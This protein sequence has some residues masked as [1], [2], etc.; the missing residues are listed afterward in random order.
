[1]NDAGLARCPNKDVLQGRIGRQR[2]AIANPKFLLFSLF[3]F[4]SFL[5]PSN[6]FADHF[7]CDAIVR[8]DI[9]QAVILLLT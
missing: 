1:M 9:I 3:L 6:C 2:I 8:G 5:V 7:A 4:L